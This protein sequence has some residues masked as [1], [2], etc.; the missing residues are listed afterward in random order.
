M[1]RTIGCRNEPSHIGWQMNY[2][3][4]MGWFGAHGGLRGVGRVDKL[5]GVAMPALFIY[6]RRKPF[7][8]HSERWLDQLGRAPGCAVLALDT[9]HWVMRQKPAEFNACVRAWLDRSTSLV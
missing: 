7:M 8:F 4:A 3:Y 5:L 6:G 9:G 1:A 2:P